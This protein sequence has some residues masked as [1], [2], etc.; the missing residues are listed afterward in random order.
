MRRLAVTLLLLVA[1]AAGAQQRPPGLELLPDI[2]PPPPP[3]VQLTPGA[4]PE[5]RI[6]RRERETIEE[7]R[8]GGQL[9]MIRVTP[10]HG[11]PYYLVDWVGDGRFTRSHGVEST[12]RVPMWVL[13]QW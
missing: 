13:F 3:T 6:I 11:V 12:L 8:F 4:E 2:P 1:T 7:F 9:Y 5:V 10:E